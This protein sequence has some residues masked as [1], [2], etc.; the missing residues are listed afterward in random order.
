MKKILLLSDTHSYLDERMLRFASEADEVWHAGD[1]GD[2]SVHD[3]LS[4]VCMVRGVYGNIDGQEIRSIHPLHKRFECQGWDVWI[5][6]IGGYPGRYHPQIRPLLYKNP[7]GIF[8]CGHSHI[9]KVIRDPK[10]GLLHMNPGA[11][12]T[13]GFHKVRTMLRFKLSPGKI[14][15][16][17]VIEL[18]PRVAGLV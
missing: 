1:W 11:A 17:E 8:I 18:G 4:A 5:T 14:E 3:S 7:P 16:M 12:G 10:T 13:H 9:L 2:V 6:H 15:E